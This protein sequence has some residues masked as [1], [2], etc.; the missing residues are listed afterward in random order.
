MRVPYS[1]SADAMKEGV[2]I[3]QLQFLPGTQ[4]FSLLPPPPLHFLSVTGVPTRT[5]H[6]ARLLEKLLAAGRTA[7]PSTRVERAPL[8]GKRTAEEPNGDKAEK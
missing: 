8:L 3:K 6:S 5:P 7:L 4:L 2:G 1:S